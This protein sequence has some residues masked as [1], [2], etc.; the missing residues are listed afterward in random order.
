MKGDTSS[1]LELDVIA[2]TMK[3]Y[4]DEPDDDDINV[5]PTNR[6]ALPASRTLEAK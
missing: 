5:P 2:S 3:P 4:D 1:K 6:T